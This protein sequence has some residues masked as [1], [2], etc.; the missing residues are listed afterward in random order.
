MT[1]RRLLTTVLAATAALALVAGCSEQ[2]APARSSAAPPLPPGLT[3]S[4]LRALPA[5]DYG[6]VIP[7]LL[8]APAQLRIRDSYKVV[9]DTAVYGDDFTTPVARLLAKNFLGEPS[10]VVRAETRGDWSLVLTP[11]RQ[12][13]PSKASA[14]SPA[15]TQSAAWVPTS[16]LR[17]TAKLDKR[18]VVSTAKQTLTVVDAQGATLDSFPVGVGAK[19]TP[20]PTG[21]GYLQARYFDPAQDQTAHR[22]QLTSLHATAAD[23]PYGG[24][25]GGLIGIHHQTTATGAV[26]HGCLR[27][28]AAAIAAVDALPL[29]TAIEIAD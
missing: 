28:S 24:S 12:K 6:A 18:V 11:A 16:A 10:V 17:H 9:F 15:P 7:G 23:E 25:D 1:L 26:S 3:T 19:D 22:I 21:T 29:G 8:A 27:L 4:T 14:A 20:T 13:L 5:A 2:P